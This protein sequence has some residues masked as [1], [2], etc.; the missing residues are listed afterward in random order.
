VG[1]G[2]V[3]GGHLTP[4]AR[5]IVVQ[6][7]GFK[8]GLAFGRRLDRSQNLDTLYNEERQAMLAP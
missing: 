1:H 8:L 5:V 6:R 4:Y 3:E 2:G 7:D